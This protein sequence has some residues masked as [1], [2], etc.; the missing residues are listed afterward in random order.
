MRT[1]GLTFR[2]RQGCPGGIT[3]D[4][5]RDLSRALL[6]PRAGW[7][8]PA[9]KGFVQQTGLNVTLRAAQ[10][11][12]VHTQVNC[13]AGH[14][15]LNVQRLSFSQDHYNSKD[16]Q[17][18]NPCCCLSWWWCVC[19][20]QHKRDSD[21]WNTTSWCQRGCVACKCK[22]QYGVISK[23]NSLNNCSRSRIWKD[24][25]WALD[26]VE[27]YVSK[28]SSLIWCM[29]VKQVSCNQVKRINIEKDAVS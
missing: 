28:A 13:Y 18:K 29:G 19:L 10:H 12:P 15:L 27:N 1:S 9:G 5:D 22:F 16:G 4:M 17:W 25:Q 26:A 24:W 6:W 11:R 8:G 21:A 3:A 14:R 2:Q 23:E 20:L 7:G